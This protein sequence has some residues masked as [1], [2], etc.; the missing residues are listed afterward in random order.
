MALVGGCAGNWVAADTISCLTCIGLG[1]GIAII[2]RSSVSCSWVATGTRCRIACTCYMALARGCAS[3]W[4]AAD[5]ISCL[6]SICLGAGIAII[7]RSSVSCSWIATGTSCRI[8][9]SGYMALVGGCAGNWVAADTISCLTSICLGTGIAIIARSSVSCS[10]IATG[11]SCRITCTCYSFQRCPGN[12]R[13]Q[14][15]PANTHQL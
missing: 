4:V 5:T 6:T 11:T 9:C 10:W 1:A 3:N 15:A 14:C 2:A 7:A 13:P 12:G 8:T